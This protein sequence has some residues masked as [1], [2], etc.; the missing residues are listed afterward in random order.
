MGREGCTLLVVGGGLNSIFGFTFG[1]SD[2]VNV[3]KGSVLS[4]VGQR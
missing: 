4:G 2:K 3:D 1:G